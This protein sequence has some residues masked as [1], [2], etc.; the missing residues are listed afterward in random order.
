[1]SISSYEQWHEAKCS[2]PK[3]AS[4]SNCE[5]LYGSILDEIGNVDG[6]DLFTNDC[7]G[8]GYVY[9]YPTNQLF[10]LHKLLLIILLILLIV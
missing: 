1:M 5:E 10:Q 6:D 2:E 9:I 7:T 3:N 8:N 4:S